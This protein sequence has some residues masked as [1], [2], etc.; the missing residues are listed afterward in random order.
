[1]SVATIVTAQSPARARSRPAFAIV[2]LGALA[3]SYSEGIDI[4]DRGQILAQSENSKGLFRP[5]LWDRG[6]VR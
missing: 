2:P 6:T 5:M 1:M 4:N 3:G